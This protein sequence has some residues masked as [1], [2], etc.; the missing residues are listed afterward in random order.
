MSL[1]PSIPS[2]ME[3]AYSEQQLAAMRQTALLQI[4]ATYFMIFAV[5]GLV[6]T[7]LMIVATWRI[8]KKAGTGG[9]KSLIPV[10]SDYTF[11][12][13]AWKKKYFFMV[14]VFIILGF[15]LTEIGLFYPEYALICTLGNAIFTIA[16]LVIDIISIV[17][18][19]KVFGKGGWFAVG[20]IFLPIIFIPILGFGK[21]KYKR[22]KRRR[23]KKALPQPENT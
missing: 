10:Y 23:R 20:I 16:A 7:T 4:F 14:L 5:I 21:A 12:K 15:A 1:I 6:F 3:M 22:R 11:Y 8:F 13:I 18:L 9:W 2:G 19:A 17:K